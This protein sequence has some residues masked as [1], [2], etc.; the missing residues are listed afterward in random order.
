MASIIKKR[1]TI[2]IKGAGVIR[3]LLWRLEDLKMHMHAGD[4]HE[5]ELRM[6]VH[7]PC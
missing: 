5:I 1:T 2:F 6:L 4:C 3:K 7:Y